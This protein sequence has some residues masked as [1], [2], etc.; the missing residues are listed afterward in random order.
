MNTKKRVLFLC[1]GNSAR[2][3]MAEGLLRSVA[4]DRFEVFSAG[5]L[6]KGLHPATIAT[7]NEIGIDVSGHRSKSVE[8]YYGQHFDY[9]ITVCDRAKQSCP[10]F[11][12]SASLHWSFEDP[13]DAPPEQQGQTFSRVREEIRERIS[14][15]VIA[16]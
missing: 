12:G 9:V 16:K 13:A 7:M 6:P 5:S 14:S 2:S 11:P 1:T 4:G 15:F 8:E 3:Q 10:I